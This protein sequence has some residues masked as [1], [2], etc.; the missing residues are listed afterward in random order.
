M[1]VQFPLVYLFGK[2]EGGKVGD[3]WKELCLC[4]LSGVPIIERGE[5]AL[6]CLEFCWEANSEDYFCPSFQFF[7]RLQLI[8]YI[9][10]D[11]TDEFYL[12]ILFLN[13]FLRVPN[14][15]CLRNQMI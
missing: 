6:P 8:Q 15:V 12:V 9:F 2:W 1:A 11:T 13:D 10:S 4:L 5:I 14:F 7:R 3:G